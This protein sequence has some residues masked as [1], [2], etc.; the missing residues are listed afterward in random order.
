MLVQKI[1]LLWKLS[2]VCDALNGFD[3]VHDDKRLPPA[4]WR[5]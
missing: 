4:F 5:I 3:Q 2:M 1:A